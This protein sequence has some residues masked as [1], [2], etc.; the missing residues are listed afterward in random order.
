[1]KGAKLRDIWER[2]MGILP[3][4]SPTARPGW[5]CHCRDKLNLARIFHSLPTVKFRAL[6]K[7]R[8]E[9]HL[10]GKVRQ[11]LGF[12]AVAECVSRTGGPRPFKVAFFG[13]RFSFE[14][15]YFH[16]EA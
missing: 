16:A 10:L 2:G 13:A 6:G 8:H 15:A 5:P 9:S 7:P 4:A 14:P 12:F 1:M 3:M 11:R